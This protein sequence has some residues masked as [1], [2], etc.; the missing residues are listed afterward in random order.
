LIIISNGLISA[1]AAGDHF[2][3]SSTNTPPSFF[4]N[5]AQIPSIVSLP[6]I[7]S[8]NSLLSTGGK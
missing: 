4:D 3:T 7:E 1:S 8:F 6:S 2:N 5:T